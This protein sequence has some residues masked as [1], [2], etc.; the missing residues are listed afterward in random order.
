MIHLK[1]KLWVKVLIGIVLIMGIYTISTKYLL[2][3][4]GTNKKNDTSL[5]KK[6]NISNS[7]KSDTLL[8][9]LE[10]DLYNEAYL[11]EYAKI[12]YSDKNNFADVLKSFLP[13]GYTGEE[14]NYIM[15]LSQNNINKLKNLEHTDISAYYQFKNFNVD[16]LKRYQDYQATH[17]YPLDKVITYVNINLDLPVYTNTKE[18]KDGNDYLVLV[19]KYNSLPNNYQPSDLDYVNGQYQNKVPMRKVAKEALEKLQQA[20]TAE[21][22]ITLNPTTAFRNQ[23]FQSTLYNNYVNKDGVEAADTYS[24][25]PGFS[26]HQT[27]LA[28]DLKNPATPANRRLN[29][30]DYAWL[31]EN[32][33]RFGFIIRFP[34]GKEFITGY[35]EENWHIRYVGEEAAKIIHDNDLTLEEYVDLYVT[36]Y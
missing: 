26:E 23:G 12:N 25:R 14:I 27:G 5:L 34:G 35:Q 1:L 4:N 29:E 28:I 13:K 19:N 3:D 32:A 7:Y 18:A 16:N 9:V 2:K 20:V 17:D 21:I 10:K 33:Y 6:Y 30:S 36:E 22:G 11:E 24:A 31:K 8:Y 15:N